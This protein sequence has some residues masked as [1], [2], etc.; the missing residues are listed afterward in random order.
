MDSVILTDVKKLLGIS[1][2]VSE[3][4]LDI[5]AAVNSAFFTLYQLGIGLTEPVQIGRGT[6]WDDF[7]TTAPKEVIREYLYLK[8]KMVFDPPTSSFVADAMKDRI[9]ETEF[10]LNIH[11]DNG[12]GVVNG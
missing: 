1:E 10:R 9:A 2:S 5:Q 4:D 8:V 6:Q 12:G 11:V 7:E 3:F